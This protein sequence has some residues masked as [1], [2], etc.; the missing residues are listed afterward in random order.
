[1][2]S[3]PTAERQQRDLAWCIHSPALARQ[4]G[5][6]CIWPDDTWFSTLPVHEVGSLP[7][8]KH[9]HHFRLGQHFEKLLQCWF[10]TVPTYDLRYANLQVNANKRTVGEFD[11]LLADRA[12]STTQHWEAAVKFYLGYGDTSQETNWFGPNTADRFDLKFGH[13]VE[14]QLLLSKHPAADALL[15]DLG[16]FVDET[17]CFMKGRLFYPFEQFAARQFSFP[18]LIN[19][20]HCKGWW[21]PI[22]RFDELDNPG[23]HFVYLQKLYWLST[24]QNDL[25]GM[26][27]E[28][29]KIFLAQD[30]QPTTMIAVVDEYGAEISRGFLVDERWLARVR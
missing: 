23:C 16:L 19:P 29:M 11:F 9:L 6:D 24:L 14:H 17:L 3:Q 28:E 20:T 10:D 8:P 22:D 4:H 21:L 7:L 1:V 27:H 26:S 13:L 5:T 2:T 25:P 30:R 18:D 15:S 12:R